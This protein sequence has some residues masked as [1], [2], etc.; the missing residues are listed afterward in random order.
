MMK[1]KTELISFKSLL[2]AGDM[3]AAI[4]ALENSD[5]LCLSK[6][7]GRDCIQ[8]VSS[9][10]LILLLHIILQIAT[11]KPSCSGE[12]NLRIATLAIQRK[13]VQAELLDRE[14]LK[15]ALA[16]VYDEAMI[17]AKRELDQDGYDAAKLLQDLDQEAVLLQAIALIFA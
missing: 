5:R 3:Q 13:M 15:I 8:I 9:Y 14:K 7:A 2:L 17:L 4:T 12:V 10:G 16:N 11:E 6:S 1:T